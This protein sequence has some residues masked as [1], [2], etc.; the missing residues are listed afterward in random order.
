MNDGVIPICIYKDCCFWFRD[1][2]SY[3]QLGEVVNQLYQPSIKIWSNEEEF[4]LLSDGAFLAVGLSQ[5]PCQHSFPEVSSELQNFERKF[6]DNFGQLPKSLMVARASKKIDA[7]KLAVM[8]AKALQKKFGFVAFEF[9][10][11][12]YFCEDLQKFEANC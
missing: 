7:S 5:T 8:L 4:T 1:E 10:E 2:I 9:Y 6:L 3:Q 11:K 12:L